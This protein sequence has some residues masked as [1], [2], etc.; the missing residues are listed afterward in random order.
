MKKF[1]SL[2]FCLYLF[3]QLIGQTVNRVEYDYTFEFKSGLY[4][5]FSDF[6][7]N[8]PVPFESLIYP[9]LADENFY[10]ILDT[11]KTIIY[12]DKHGVTVNANTS[13]LWGF[14]RNGKPYIYWSNKVNLI[15]FVGSISHFITTIKVAYSTYQDPFY[16]PY[17][18]SPSA[19]VYQSE[20]L[21]Q[22]IIDME[23]GKVMEYNINNVESILQR[24]L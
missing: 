12:N 23:T 7:N 6:R 10:F 17:Y 18:Y 14:S 19:R 3:S 5:T 11:A 2:I 4:T 13:S 15:P 9:Y 21:R 24:S 8:S 20:E 16:D 1:A 22:F